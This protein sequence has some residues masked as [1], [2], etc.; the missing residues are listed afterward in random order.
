MKDQLATAPGEQPSLGVVEAA[1]RR[2]IREA[3]LPRKQRKQLTQML[4][5][6]VLMQTVL[7]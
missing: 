2:F 6:Y 5:E 7:Q 3:A 1:G 4:D